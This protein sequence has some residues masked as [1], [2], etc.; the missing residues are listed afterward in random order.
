MSD[1]N[2]VG[3]FFIGFILGGLVGALA[4]LLYAPQS[5]EETRVLIKDKSIE[6]RDKA[7]Q[8]AEQARTRTNE[9]VQQVKV[10]GQTALES[11][12]GNGTKQTE[13]EATV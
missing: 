7:Q 5:G 10:Q 3:L 12:R 4:A 8:T 6:L 13:P 1:R 2:G 11:M 9:F